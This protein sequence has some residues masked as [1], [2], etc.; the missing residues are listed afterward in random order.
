MTRVNNGSSCGD[1]TNSSSSP[2]KAVR[3]WHFCTPPHLLFGEGKTFQ[4]VVSYS[5]TSFGVPRQR[6]WILGVTGA[7][8][9]ST[10]I[11]FRSLRSMKWASQ[12]GYSFLG[13]SMRITGP[14]VLGV[15]R[16][17]E[18]REALR[19]RILNTSPTSPN[20]TN[21]PPLVLCRVRGGLLTASRGGGAEVDDET[22]GSETA[23]TW[24]LQ[25]PI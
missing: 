15:R 4:T 14:S 1:L 21:S 6:Y 19:V 3:N 18:V 22:Q 9:S 20:G 2:N 23:P 13:R 10:K 16:G 8:A 25:H 7:A 24:T 11:V 5:I 17:A 12:A